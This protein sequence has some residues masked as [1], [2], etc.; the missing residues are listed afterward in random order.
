MTTVTFSPALGRTRVQFRYDAAVVALIKATVP[1][2][3]RSYEPAAR[4]WYV[5]PTWVPSLASV[6]RARG[7]LVIEPERTPP[8]PPPP[9]RRTDA[10]WAQQ[11]FA[12]VGPHRQASVYRALSRVLHPDTS[13]GD[14]T[15]Q[16]QLNAAYGEASTNGRESA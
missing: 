13:T 10:T 9:Q 6:L 7:H 11:L 14:H 16:L 8:P 1:G 4:C 5:N 12:A 3:C 2:Y 15:L